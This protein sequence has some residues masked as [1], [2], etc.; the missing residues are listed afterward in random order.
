MQF[1]EGYQKNNIDYCFY[2][3]FRIYLSS[4]FKTPV[5][6]NFLF[7]IINEY[8]KNIICRKYINNF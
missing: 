5:F 2:Y 7:A 1:V 4:L 6:N 3:T 8:L